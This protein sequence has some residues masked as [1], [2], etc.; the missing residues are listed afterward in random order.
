MAVYLDNSAT[1]RVCEEALET[2]IAVSRGE[3]GNPSSRHLLGKAAEDLLL[4]ARA[5]INRSLGSKDGTVI[6][7]AGGTE[8]NNLA[9]FGRAYAKPRYRKGGK[10]LTTLGEH[11]SVTQPLTALANEGFRVVAIPT[12]G[13]KLDLEALEREM[14][15][16]VIL[17]TMMLV[18]N[19]TGAVYDLAYVSRLMRAYAPDAILHVDATQAYLKIPFTVKSLDADLVTISSH[20][21]EGPKGVGALWVSPA[22]VKNRGLVPRELGGG[23]EHGYRSG[24]ENVPGIAA[25]GAAI[26][27]EMAD[28]ETRMA[29]ATRLSQKLI[30]EIANRESL[31]EVRVNLPARRAPHI[32]SITLPKI[33]SETMLH[34]LSARGIYVS[35]GSACSS[36]DTHTSP[37]IVAFGLSEAEADTTI[38]VSLGAHNTEA[39]IDALLEG[40]EAGVRDLIRIR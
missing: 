2:Y 37:A 33:K 22:V 29:L 25:F 31:H 20:K 36:H 15:P 18:N 30:D 11:S 6:F 3:F 32:V 23:Q 5:T 38:R 17:V 7:T 12:K 24:T 9:I 1:T 39:D 4:D 26:R 8:A 16:D 13:G 10:I 28:R 21:V 34:F 19:E 14:T 35:S 40:L 27:K